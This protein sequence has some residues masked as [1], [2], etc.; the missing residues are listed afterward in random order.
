[1]SR[2]YMTQ[3]HFA[4]ASIFQN[5]SKTHWSVNIDFIPHVVTKA[6]LPRYITVIKTRWKHFPLAIKCP[7]LHYL[8]SNNL[9]Y[10]MTAIL[11]PN[12]MST[13]IWYLLTFGSILET[14]SYLN[15]GSIWICWEC[16]GTEASWLPEMCWCTKRQIPLI[17]FL[18]RHKLYLTVIKDIRLGFQCYGKIISFSHALLLV[19][20]ALYSEPGEVIRISKYY[21]RRSVDNEDDA[22]AP[23]T[24]YDL[25]W[26]NPKVVSTSL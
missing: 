1:M 18:W 2:I 3:R 11:I 19:V 6:M 24:S 9:R 7:Y 25:I 14:Y 17:S 26:Y 5:S 12:Y 21:H 4:R 13:Q 23:V 8:T 20:T 10:I 16:T 22:W 15:T